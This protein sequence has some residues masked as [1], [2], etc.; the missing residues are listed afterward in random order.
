VFFSS[1][2]SAETDFL[3]RINKTNMYLSP[4]ME[5]C[6]SCWCDIPTISSLHLKLYLINT[7]LCT[8]GPLLGDASDSGLLKDLDLTILDE[9]I[10]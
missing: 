9:T 8:V 5:I 1:N 2:T 3:H 6:S 4:Y 7:F 10:L